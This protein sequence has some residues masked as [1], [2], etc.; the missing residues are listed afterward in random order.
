VTINNITPDRV[1]LNWQALGGIDLGFHLS[2]RFVIE[3]EPDFRYYFDSVYEKSGSAYK[4]WSVGIR[5]AFLV[6]F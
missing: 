2:Q 5:A 4:P 1:Q 6:N 3:L